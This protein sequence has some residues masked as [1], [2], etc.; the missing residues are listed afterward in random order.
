MHPQ[1]GV[2]ASLP[3]SELSNDLFAQRGGKRL[4]ARH[5]AGLPYRFADLVEVGGATGAPGQV[6]LKAL[7]LVG[8]QRVVEVVG[9]D[10]DH[11]LAAVLGVHG[12]SLLK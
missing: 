12:A 1:R 6:A 5:H 9:D 10:L 8:R 11:L 7:L 3:V 4:L 2:L